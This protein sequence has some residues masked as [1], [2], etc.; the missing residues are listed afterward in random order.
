MEHVDL[1]EARL[2]RLRG[3][4]RPLKQD[5]GELLLERQL[6]DGQATP[7]RLVLQRRG[8]LNGDSL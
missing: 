3:I 7:L 2:A 4:L 1:L 5:D 8:M 6:T